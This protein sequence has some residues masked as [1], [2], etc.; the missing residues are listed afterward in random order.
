MPNKD[1]TGTPNDP[2]E[3]SELQRQ[4]EALTG[5]M[6][7]MLEVIG[8]LSEKLDKDTDSTDGL[9]GGSSF[10]KR[11]K[12][13]NSKFMQSVYKRVENWPSYKGL[14]DNTHPM[15]FLN[16]LEQCFLNVGVSEAEK[17]SLLRTK[18]ISD[19]QSWVLGLSQGLTYQ[20]I[21]EKFIEKFWSINIQQTIYVKFLN[22]T[23]NDRQSPSDFADYWHTKLQY[24]VVCQNELAFL[25]SLRSK[26]PQNMQSMLLG[27]AM[28]SFDKFR[29]RLQE[30]ELINN[31]SKNHNAYRK[32]NVNMISDDIDLSSSTSTTANSSSLNLN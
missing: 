9:G 20:E 32:P 26:F 29:E 24:A 10:E 1:K 30:A 28:T 4:V 17:A 16:S 23:Y 27:D 31:T 22:A 18:L 8:K 21:K 14:S 19:A 11:S 25:L 3:K 15:I 7:S 13:E 5:Q 12:S 2:L 6:A